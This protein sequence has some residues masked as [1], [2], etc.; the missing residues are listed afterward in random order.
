MELDEIVFDDG[1]VLR[2]VVAELGYDYAVLP[3]V[4]DAKDAEPGE[5]EGK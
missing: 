1:T 2:F 3:I 5:K 4:V